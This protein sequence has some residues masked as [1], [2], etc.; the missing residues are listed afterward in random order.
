M[1]AL[2]DGTLRL[3]GAWTLAHAAL[4]EALVER[5]P[6]ATAIDGRAIARLDSAGALLLERLLRNGGVERGKLALGGGHAALLQLV[7]ANSDRPAPVPRRRAQPARDL[8]AHV[9]RSTTDMLTQGRL[10]LGFLG[11]VLGTLAKL[12]LRP[13]RL[14]LTPT[15]HHMEQAGFDAV[16]L[17]CLLNF[18]VGAVIAYLGANVLREFGAEIYVV[19]LVSVSFL[20]EFGVLLTAILLAGRTA[21]AFTAQIGSMKSRE[22]IDAIRTLGLD[23]I[24]L[25]VVPRLLALVVMLPLLS[26]LATVAGLL[27]GMAVGSAE[28]GV[29]NEVFLARFEDTFR[30][31][32]M[33]VGLAKA[34]IFAL[35]IALIGCLEG[36]KVAGTAQSVGERTTSSVVQ[37]IFLVVLLDALAAVYTME[38]GW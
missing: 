26:F 12:L 33:L 20:R 21:S 3:S 1:D 9:G 8:L 32:H 18:L 30:L 24:E 16:P 22:E 6:V 37:A 17:V 13:W 29:S 11:L 2:P 36:F 5:P 27:G 23:P 14:R 7:G 38:M 25:L 35:V 4:L 10:L 15:V 34:P 31:R 28:L 19:E